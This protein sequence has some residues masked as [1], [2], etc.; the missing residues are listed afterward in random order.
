[1]RFM[2]NCFI[3][4][5]SYVKVYNY[6]YTVN[7]FHRQ[8]YCMPPAGTLYGAACL[9]P[10]G[11]ASVR[12]PPFGADVPGTFAS[13][14]FSGTCGSHDCPATI[15]NSFVYTKYCTDKQFCLHDVF[16]IPY[17]EL[18]YIFSF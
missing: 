4:S 15:L 18:F 17:T 11:D 2:R 1:M 6:S 3:S 5:L 7:T 12:P 14:E 13:P 16:Y 8:V 10:R 9:L